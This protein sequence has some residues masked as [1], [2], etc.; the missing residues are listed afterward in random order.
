VL[1]ESEARMTTETQS[2][3]ITPEARALIGVELEPVT[4][5]I[6]K[7]L[8]KRF[9]IAVKWP[10]PPNPL[11]HDEAYAAK[12]AYSGIIAAPTISGGFPWLGPIL[13]RLNPT[14]GKYRVGLNGGNEY[15]FFEPIRPGDVL[16]ARPRVTGLSEKPRDDG[17]VMLVLDLEAEFFN[18]RS[19]RVLAA[20]QT[21]LRI[22]GPDQLIGA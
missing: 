2:K 4:I 9:A 6:D 1:E 19:E 3:V 5:E 12:T 14:M 10:N 15:E 11:Y 18:Q 21:L 13:E 16:S 22:Y 17:G 20:R 8:L 7:T